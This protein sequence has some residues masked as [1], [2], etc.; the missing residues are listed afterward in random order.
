MVQYDNSALIFLSQ[1]CIFDFSFTYVLQKIK[2]EIF[3]IF[4]TLFLNLKLKHVFAVFE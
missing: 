2:T 3:I 4:Q 1:G